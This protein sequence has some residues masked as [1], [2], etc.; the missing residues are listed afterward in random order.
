MSETF[1]MVAKTF[2]GLEGVLADELTALGAQDVTQGVRVVAF[3]GDKELMYRANFAC[4]T[5]LRILKPFAHFTASDPD[6]LYEQVRKFD[7]EQILQVNQTFQIDSTA[8]S[9]EFRNSRFVTYRTKD[10]IVDYFNDKYGKRPSIRLSN[11]DRRIDVHISGHDV[12]LSLDSSGE[13]LYRRGWRVAQTE[14]PLNEVLAAGMILL[15]GW[16][17]ECDLVDPMCGSGTIA[18]EAALIALNIN[19]GVFRK[20]FAFQKWDDYDADLFSTIYDDDSGERPFEHKIYA[21]D[22]DAKA[23]AITRQNALNAAVAQYIVLERKDIADITEAP[24][25]GVLITNPPYGER[26]EVA[27]GLYHTIGERLKRVF[28]GYNAWLLCYE[29]E[30]YEHIGLKPSIHYPLLN[31]AL[32]CELREYV[33]FEGSYN[34]MRREGGSIKNED[35]RASDPDRRRPLHWRDRDN[36]EDRPP[37]PRREFHHDDRRPPHREFRHDD[38]RE[39]RHE[40]DDRPPRHEFRHDDRHDFNVEGRQP[41]L[42]PDKEVPIVHGRRKSWKRREYDERLD[43]VGRHDH[44]NQPDNNPTPDDNQQ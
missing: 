38:R 3:K 5:A 21:S 12:T 17:G 25:A 19:P 20:E 24:P 26:L 8:Y 6:D 11:P 40:G 18:I 27:E 4:R 1:N 34:D 7:W 44:D 37:R 22:I 43:N 30:H 13:P 31:G 29:R 10:A 23:I 39:F 28:T 16:H 14:A 2:Q 32:E 33:I 9:E 35:F 36:D 41:R 42:S 15:S